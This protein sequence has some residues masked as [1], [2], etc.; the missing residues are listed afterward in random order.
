MKN[1]VKDRVRDTGMPSSPPDPRTPPKVDPKPPAP[2]E[3]KGTDGGTDEPWYL[4]GDIDAY[5][6]ENTDAADD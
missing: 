3:P 2:A 6:W 5:G 4:Q 1:A